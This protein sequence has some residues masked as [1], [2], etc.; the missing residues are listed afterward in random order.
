MIRIAHVSD[1]H[2]VSR[3]AAEWRR[4]VFNK[5]LTGYANLMLHRGRVHRRQYLLAVL[6]DARIVPTLSR[7]D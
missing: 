4:I 5:R 3:T 7:A 6:S 1:L 2:V